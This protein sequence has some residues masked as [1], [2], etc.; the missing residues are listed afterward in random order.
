MKT[1]QFKKSTNLPDLSKI[2]KKPAPHYS[3]TNFL[4][5]SLSLDW[6]RTPAFLIKKNHNRFLYYQIWALCDF[7]STTIEFNSWHHHTITLQPDEPEFSD[8]FLF[9][10]CFP[11]EK[12]SNYTQ[13]SLILTFV[14]VVTQPSLLIT[15]LPRNMLFILCSQAFNIRFTPYAI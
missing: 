8:W 2:L 5:L 12:Q 3:H 11:L 14:T 1:N 15:V 4:H 9:Y 7:F 6:Y 10:N 13:I